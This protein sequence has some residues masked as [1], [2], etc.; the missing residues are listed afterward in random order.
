MA[1]SPSPALLSLAV[2]EVR[3]PASVV[4]GYLRML[5]SDVAGPLTDEQRRMV[6]GAAHSCARMVEIIA[7]LSDVAK[8]DAGQIALDRRPLDVFALAAEVAAG[9]HEARERDVHLA[10]HGEQSGVTIAGD[11]RRLRS[12]LHAVFRAVIWD[13]TGPCT[14]VVDCRRADVDG[15]SCAVIIV[16]DEAHVRRAFEAA[17]EPFDDLRGGLGLAL[18]LARRV[19]ESHGG[20]L[21]APAADAVPRASA[22]IALPLAQRT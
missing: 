4:G 13:K 16:A 12:S 18:P 15:L 20:S 9:V 5:Q 1:T 21:R 22:V 8:F 19:I 7:E 11:T 6:A 14:I 2:H 10:V 3:T 17:S